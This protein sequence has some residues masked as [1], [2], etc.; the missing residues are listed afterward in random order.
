LKGNSKTPHQKERFKCAN[1]TEHYYS[2]ACRTYDTAQDWTADRIKT[3]ALWF[4]GKADNDANEQ[5]YVKL[6]DAD[7]NSVKVMYDGDANDLKSGRSGVLTC[8][9]SMM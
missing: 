6:E 2:E 3:L 1:Y 4:Y 7:G 5:M 9:I 8:K